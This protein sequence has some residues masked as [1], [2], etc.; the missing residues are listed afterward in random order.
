MTFSTGNPP[1]QGESRPQGEARS[2]A[3][4]DQSSRDDRIKEILVS[5]LAIHDTASAIDDPQ[6]RRRYL[7]GVCQGDQD[8]RQRVEAML[9][10]KDVPEAAL[11]RVDQ[12]LRAWLSVR[13][14]A[15]RPFKRRD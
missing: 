4:D 5:P 11:P 9:H 2:V 8:L 6:A 3:G 7:D 14:S 15:L 10:L 12:F 13:P 1:L